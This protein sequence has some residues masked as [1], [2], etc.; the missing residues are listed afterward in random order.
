VSQVDGLKTVFGQAGFALARTK[1]GQRLVRFVVV[2]MSFIL[3][4]DK[5]RQTPT[6]MAFYHPKPVYPVHILIVPRRSIESLSALGPGDAGFLVELI[7][8]VKSLVTELGLEKQGYRLIANGGQYQ[9]LPLL[10]FHLVSGTP[11]I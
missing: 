5:L 2:N 3:P 6:L 1:L 4:V 9:D 10:H 8:T 11:K 7:E